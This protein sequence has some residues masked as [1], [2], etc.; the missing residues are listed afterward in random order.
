M[1]TLNNFSEDRIRCYILCPEY[2]SDFYNK[3]KERY[4]AGKKYAVISYKKLYDAIDDTAIASL[5][6]DKKEIIKDLKR[7]IKRYTIKQNDYYIEK[8]CGRFAERIK[9]LKEEKIN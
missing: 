6:E 2:K 8:I 1:A 3:E 5:T 7:T 4:V 9:R